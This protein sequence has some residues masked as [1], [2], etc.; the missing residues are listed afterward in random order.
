MKKY[1]IELG[2]LL[3]TMVE[4][5]KGHEVE[6]T[7]GTNEITSTAEFWLAPI[8]SPVTASWPRAT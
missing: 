7:V 3:F 4:P 8:R 6:S 1:P 2:T 5:H